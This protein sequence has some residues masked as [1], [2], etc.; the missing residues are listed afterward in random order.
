MSLLLGAFGIF[1]THF[2]S[3]SGAIY[4]IISL[5]M[6]SFS[7][8]VIAAVSK[9]LDKKL[10]LPSKSQQGSRRYVFLGLLAGFVPV[11]LLAYLFGVWPFS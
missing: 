11:L 1:D 2:M 5:V 4:S 6:A 8:F 10:Q 9:L 3:A 7:L